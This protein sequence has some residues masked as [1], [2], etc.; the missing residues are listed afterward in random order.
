MVDARDRARRLIDGAAALVRAADAEL[1]GLFQPLLHRRG[2]KQ[3]E[4]VGGDRTIVACALDGV[5]ERAVLHHQADRMLEVG[6]GRVP[7]LERTPP[8]RPF[9]LR[10]AAAP[11]SS[12]STRGRSA[13]TRTVRT[14]A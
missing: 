13:P 8:E 4:R 6:V 10:S 2:R 5:F 12:T 3:G 9:A 11:P 7:L 14:R 1:D